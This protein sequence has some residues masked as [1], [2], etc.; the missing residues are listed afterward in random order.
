MDKLLI[1]YA[2]K[3]GEN[4]PFFIVMDLDEEE[5]TNIIKTSIEK[6]EP[7]VVETNDDVV[8]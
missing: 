6:N 1:E 8:Y 3:F 2:E 4:F 7:Y 5:I